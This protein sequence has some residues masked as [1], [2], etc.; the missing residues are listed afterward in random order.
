MVLAMIRQY[1][2][3]LPHRPIAPDDGVMTTTTIP[4]GYLRKP[5]ALRYLKTSKTT[6][7]R[8]I[9]RGEVETR[10]APRSGGPEIT[11]ISLA[12]LEEVKRSGR[13]NKPPQPKNGNGLVA[14][15]KNDALAA[16]LLKLLEAQAETQ[17]SIAA[18]AERIP[19]NQK[20]W[21]TLKEA[22]ALSGIPPKHLRILMLAEEFEAQRFGRSWRIHRESLE[23]WRP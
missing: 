22:V 20:I 5:E 7:D 19:P 13:L 18:A 17:R 12:S 8:L 16:A 21:L 1:Q 23:R 4:P 15:S 10:K 6:L 14:K 9:E 2:Q 3:R 11:L